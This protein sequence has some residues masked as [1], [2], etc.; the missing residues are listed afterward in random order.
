MRQRQDAPSWPT[1]AAFHAWALKSG[2]APG[3]HLTRPNRAKAASPK[4]AAWLPVAESL[5]YRRPLTANHK[6]KRLIR[7]FGERKGA[8]EWAND[9]RCVVTVAG[10]LARLDRGMKP[11]DAI[12][13]RKRREADY[14]SS[15]QLTAWGVEKTIAAW[16]RDRR[17]KVGAFTI[18]RRLA[19][20]W[21]PEAAIST[22]AFA[23]PR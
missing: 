6:P 4:N 17:A 23:R 7:A 14:S 13:K 18:R 11:Q 21:T 8:T 1:F 3:L 5:S 16:T 2:Y 9:P 20:G 15:K 22:A 12:T 19:D 10:L